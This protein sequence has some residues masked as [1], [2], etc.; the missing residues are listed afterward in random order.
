MGDDVSDAAQAILALLK[1][2]RQGATICPS[3]AA[4]ACGGIDWRD[5]MPRVHRAARRLVETGAIVLTQGG[6]VTAPE[7][8]VGPYRIAPA[9]PGAQ[10]RAAAI[11]ADDSR[12]EPPVSS[13]RE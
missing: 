11:A 1:T 6:V 8:I 4:R 2:R 12:G 5:A 3:D 7:G 9:A 10:A 13:P